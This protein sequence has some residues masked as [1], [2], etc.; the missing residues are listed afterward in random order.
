MGRYEANRAMTA[1]SLLSLL[2]VAS[3]ARSTLS[4]GARGLLNK[5]P[6][7]GV[8]HAIAAMPLNYMVTNGNGSWT[9]SAFSSSNNGAGGYA[10]VNAIYGNTALH[11]AVPTLIGS[12]SSAGLTQG[13]SRQ[14]GFC[15]SLDCRYMSG[16]VNSMVFPSKFLGVAVGA[17]GDLTNTATMARILLTIDGGLTWTQVSGL[18]TI[19]GADGVVTATSTAIPYPV[20]T[21]GDLHCVYMSSKTTGWAVGSTVSAYSLW[22]FNFN[23]P[24]GNSNLW[25]IGAGV[26]YM[27]TMGGTVWSQIPLFYTKS[28]A[29]EVWSNGV[30]LPTATKLY[31]Q[32]IPG[33]LFSI[34][35]D[36]SGRN[37]FAVGAAPLFATVAAGATSVSWE[38]GSG[39]TILYSA[40]RGVTWVSQVAPAHA[41][42]NFGQ[43]YTLLSV[44]VA[45]GTTAWAV[46]GDMYS[47]SFSSGASGTIIGT[48]N[49]GLSWK[50]LIYPIYSGASAP[51]FTSV[52]YNDGVVWVAGSFVYGAN[53]FYPVP[54]TGTTP[55]QNYNVLVSMDG[56]HFAGALAYAQFPPGFV[57]TS[58]CGSF[59]GGTTCAN[60]NFNYKTVYGITWDNAVHGWIF[61]N[62]F[63]LAT[64]D[65]GKTWVSELPND[66]ATGAAHG[67]LTS[68]TYVTVAMMGIYALASVPTTY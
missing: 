54:A 47:D 61:G 49:G 16:S 56:V 6:S 19:T 14:A 41:N 51:I 39:G 28:E 62:S 30:A 36:A 21:S 5:N 53:D 46:G 2:V 52:T 60:S 13:L 58:T 3:S 23:N 66:I 25:G 33:P 7:S 43:G 44:A 31:A 63:L 20:V 8:L 45:K 59:S 35:A 57:T 9:Y 27:T 65:G 26:I 1:M 42:S 24:T 68:T 18:P 32:Q 55:G 38:M 64:H 40:N 50:N 48:T 17:N 15:G 10:S 11:A 34:Q 4:E 37:V 12:S 67:M 22:N 29:A